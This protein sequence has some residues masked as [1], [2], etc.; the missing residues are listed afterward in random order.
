MKLHLKDPAG[1]LSL[2]GISVQ[3]HQAIVKIWRYETEYLASLVKGTTC[4][5]I[6]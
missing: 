5:V 4:L 1:I 3:V 6:I 2:D